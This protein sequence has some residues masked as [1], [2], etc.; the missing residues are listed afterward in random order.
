MTLFPR[1][2]KY[3]TSCAFILGI[4]FAVYVGSFTHRFGFSD[5]Y[6][7]MFAAYHNQLGGILE[8][9]VAGGRPIYAL[10]TMIFVFTPHLSD[11]VWLRLFSIS[12]IAILSIYIADLLLAV[13]DL[14]GSACIT[15]AILISMTPAF[16]VYSVWAVA[17]IYPWAA[18]LAAMSFCVL[19]NNYRN[20]WKRCVFSLFLLLLSVMTYQ[21]AAMMYWVAAAA[22]WVATHRRVPSLRKLALPTA[23]MFLAL[24]IDFAASKIIPIIV[25][26]NTH[27]F[28]RAAL[29]SNFGQKAAWFFS[30]P[31]TD[32]L[33]F[34]SI[35]R[36]TR[37]AAFVAL[38][39]AVGM[40]LFF[41]A[42]SESSMGKAA[43]AAILV[44][45][46]YLPNLI[47]K[48]DW[49]SYRTQVALTSLLTLYGLIAV[50]AYCKLFR[51]RRILPVIMLLTILLC[52]WVAHENSMTE[53]VNPQV[54]EFKIIAD[55]VSEKSNIRHANEI[56]IVPS[57]W[58]ESLAPVV[59]YDEFGILSS[60]NTWR[61]VGMI[62]VILRREHARNV[63]A[64]AKAR[65]GT[66]AQAPEGATVVNLRQALE[67]H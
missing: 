41:S 62:W 48:E 12:G 57:I 14:P 61:S 8:M 31:L 1:A 37:V 11:L 54:K 33:N 64:I 23:I 7:V 27:H 34:P 2:I 55:Y 36:N 56:Y 25:F 67:G 65:A 45:L 30:Q 44:P 52:A 63:E 50:V 51:L 17:A 5:D 26:N 40:G 22:C 3:A 66:L 60:S 46:S 6:A 19:Q 38:F 39:V 49:A 42:R 43:L 35:V 9:N 21:P 58:K 20:M 53:L 18:L 15:A 24:S 29:I 47:V 4:C 59:R 32:A 10:F 13:S 16:Q 28:A